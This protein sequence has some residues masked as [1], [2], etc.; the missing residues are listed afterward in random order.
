MPR[1]DLPG[2]RIVELLCKALEASRD[3]VEK[4]ELSLGKM[5]KVEWDA[6][7]EDLDGLNLAA[8]LGD[9]I[10]DGINVAY[11][12]ESYKFFGIDVVEE[13]SVIIVF[14]GREMAYLVA[15]VVDDLEIGSDD[16]DN[17]ED[18]VITFDIIEEITKRHGVKGGFIPLSHSLISVLYL[19]IHS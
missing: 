16:G 9:E 3:L 5:A 10:E 6:P 19:P 8:T 13:P 12:D 2:V 17:C 11:I 7:D 14:N 4:G 18:I 1:E 15:Q